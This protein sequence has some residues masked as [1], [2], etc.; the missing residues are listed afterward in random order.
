MNTA[1]DVDPLTNASAPGTCWT[2]SNMAE[3]T[4]G[5]LTPAGW[6]FYGRI[7]DLSSRL[8]FAELGVL[9]KSHAAYPD[10]VNQRLIGTFHGRA[11]LNV[12]V[13]R[14][15]MSG[16]PGVSGDDI[17]RDIVGAVRSGVQ[18][19]GYGCRL[20][21][22]AVKAPRALA[23]SARGARKVR[24]ETAAWWAARFGPQGLR[25][26]ASPRVVLAEAVDRFGAAVVAQSRNRLI[27]QG[28]SSQLGELAAAAGR[29]DLAASLLS[30][31]GRLEEL[32]VAED[33]HA[34]AAGRL[35]EAEFLARHG[36]H[37]P[38]A[39]DITAHS[40]RE[41]PAPLRRQV[42]TLAR[43]ATPPRV[44]DQ[45]ARAEAVAIVL[46]RLPRHKRAGARL[47]LK[48]AP[49]AALSLERS[50]TAFVMSIDGARA[51]VRACGAELVAAGR[52]SEAD[53]AFYL[54]V[55]ELLR[56]PDGDLRGIVEA[57]KADRERYLRVE[58]VE[59]TWEGAPPIRP[60][61]AEQ[62]LDVREVTG[63][64]ASPG[65]VEGVVRVV[66]D[67]GAQ[68]D[69]EPGDIL[70]CPVTDPSWVS[71]MTIAGALV[72][73]IGGPASHG[74]IVA[75]ELG[76]PCVIGTGTGT[77]DLRD[78]DLVRIDGGAGVVTVIKRGSGADGQ[79]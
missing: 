48:M 14:A 23:R 64:G 49:S 26:G 22:V 65:V 75:R 59:N 30:G 73:D 34:L 11:C 74:A 72:I 66:L 21:L 45:A 36:Y 46:E 7:V 63:N 8:G 3:V 39:G 41:D 50:K 78:G 67:A 70:V 38:N 58:F 10:D 60:L 51:A 44:V 40:W 76:L 37:G 31:A 13:L 20:P 16:L 77:R 56:R 1:V 12:T 71:M 61:Q 68:T 53:D 18:D 42:A 79:A 35:S 29:P 25:D 15:I 62:T 28:S 52:L 19:A 2:R 69:V 43:T 33:L 55:D 47:A 5:I 4:P 27:Y 17:E 24:T 54:F 57:R 9:P 32:E 6:S